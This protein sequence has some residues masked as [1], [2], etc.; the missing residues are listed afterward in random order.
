MSSA[1]WMS[2]AAPNLKREEPRR[3]LLNT[4]I[5][6]LEHANISAIACLDEPLFRDCESQQLVY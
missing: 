1:P 2:A 6:G 4:V 3:P 5:M